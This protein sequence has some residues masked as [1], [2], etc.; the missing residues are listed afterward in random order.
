MSRPNRFIVVD[1]DPTSNMICGFALQGFSPEA[2]ITLLTEPEEALE[3]IGRTYA[4]PAEVSPAVLFLDL[5]MP[6][7]TGWEFLGELG[8]LGQEV[9]EWLTVY[10]LS[11]SLDAG[12]MEQAENHPL[13]S[14]FIPKP[15]TLG[16]LREK[17]GQG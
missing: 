12:D 5:N 1:D 10:I 6:S 4:G 14:G 16:M 7:M 17:F 3:F 13:V 15:L 9:R 11:S 2:E 8:K